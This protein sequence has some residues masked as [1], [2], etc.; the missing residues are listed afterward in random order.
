MEQCV[1]QIGTKLEKVL[2]GTD[3]HGTEDQLELYALGRLPEAEIPALE[4]HLIACTSC[5]ERLDGVADF[6]VAIRDALTAEPVVDV[7]K[8]HRSSWFGWLRQP[9]YSMSIAFIALLVVV[10]IFSS[11][12]TKLLPSASLQLTAMRGAMPE[13]VPARELDLTLTDGPQDGGPFRVEVLTATGTIRWSQ[14]ASSTPGG[15]QVHVIRR[16]T[17]GDYLVRLY[18]ASG[19]TLR[20]YGFR[21]RG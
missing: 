7:R 11:Q 16:L 2:R 3:V 13:T 4:E 20:E 9:A 1:E 15:M 19:K 10:G 8:A 14:L 5:Q 17:P 18:S 6:A 21:V 12:R